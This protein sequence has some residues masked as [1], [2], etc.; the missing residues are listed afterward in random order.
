MD[1]EERPDIVGVASSIAEVI[2]THMDELRTRE[3]ML[4]KKL[5]REK[6]RVQK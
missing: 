1:S 3:F 5:Q 4:Q 2:M 6:K